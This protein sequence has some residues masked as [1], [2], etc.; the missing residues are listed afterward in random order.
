[1]SRRFIV[2]VDGLDR[3]DEARLSEFLRSVKGVHWWHWI[4]NF[5]LVRTES[6][7]SLTTDDIYDEIN[8]YP[9]SQRIFVMEIQDDVDWACTEA[10]NENGNVMTDWLKAAW[11][12]DPEPHPKG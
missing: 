11:R 5:W 1:M 6:N 4:P 2:A 8:S 7:F 12:A 3:A 10:V 9:N